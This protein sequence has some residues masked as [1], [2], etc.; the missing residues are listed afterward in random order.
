[1]VDIKWLW[2]NS[3][4]EGFTFVDLFCGCGGVSQGFVDCGFEP[5]AAVDFFD[6]ACETH[7]RN[8]D[9]EVIEGD[10]TLDET[11]EKLYEITASRLNGRELDV[12]HASPPCQGFSMARKR[13]LEDPR[14][15]LYKEAIKIIDKLNPRWITMENVPGIVSMLNGDVVQQ[16]EEDLLNIGY[17]SK[18]MVLNAA[19]YYTPQTR[20]RWILIGTRTNKEIDFPLPLVDKEHYVTVGNA[21]GDLVGRC[22]DKELSHIFTRH[23]EEMQQRLTE[24]EE[25]KSLYEKYPESWR[26]S[27]WNEPSCT[28]KENHG[29]VNIHPKLPRVIT[30]REMARIQSFSDNFL[31]CGSKKD[32]MAQIGNAVPPNLARAIGMT[33][34]EL[35]KK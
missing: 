14:N 31:F 12:L 24:V 11:K 15:Q 21:I 2:E 17:R 1:M 29:A 8:I 33:L 35:N 34:T 13:S 5:I 6:S 20:K 3:R 9:C 18:W 26:K 28:I 27:P 10:I 25:G 22:E 7:R 16:I 32:Q 30:P 19:D 23:S 4:K